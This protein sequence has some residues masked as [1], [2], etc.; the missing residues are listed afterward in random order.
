[1]QTEVSRTFSEREKEKR[2]FWQNDD[3]EACE[4]IHNPIKAA[5]EIPPVLNLSHIRVLAGQQS[6]ALLKKKPIVDLVTARR[7]KRK[8]VGDTCVLVEQLH[9]M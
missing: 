4:I 9:E 7:R 3:G 8:G 5:K 2:H 6:T 1:M